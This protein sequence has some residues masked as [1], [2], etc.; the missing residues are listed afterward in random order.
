[1]DDGVAVEVAGAG[2]DAIDGDD[3]ALRTGGQC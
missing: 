2:E 1:V 3:D